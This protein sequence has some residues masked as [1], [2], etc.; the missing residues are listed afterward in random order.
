MY[1][2][3]LLILT[4]SSSIFAFTIKDIDTFQADF[5]QSIINPSGKKIQYNG[6]VFIKKPLKILWKY[7]EPIEKNVYLIDSHVTIIEP[8]L[9]QVIISTLKDE[10]N[11]LQI[12]QNG[13]EITKNRYESIIYNKSYIF[14]VQDNKLT[15][16]EYQDDVDNK[17]VITFN[18]IIQNKPIEDTIYKFHIPDEYDIIR[19]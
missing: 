14:S 12:L 4:F 8:E 1:K 9:E 15:S 17:V 7:N 10:I 19:K 18:Q 13:K 2:K 6:K 3:I 5:T 16:I 11:I